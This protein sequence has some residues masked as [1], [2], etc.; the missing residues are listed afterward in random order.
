[1]L[2]KIGNFLSQK[3]LSLDCQIYLTYQ[4]PLTIFGHEMSMVMV[5]VM[6]MGIMQKYSRDYL[7]I[8]MYTRNMQ[9][10]NFRADSGL[11]S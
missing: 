10:A 8:Q 2:L 1:M 5:M 6:V 9:K 4:T 11:V 7:N 3:H